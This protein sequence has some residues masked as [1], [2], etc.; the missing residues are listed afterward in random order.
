MISPAYVWR[1]HTINKLN[2][3]EIPFPT[4]TTESSGKVFVDMKSK[5]GICCK[6][7]DDPVNAKETN[8]K[9]HILILLLYSI[10]GY[11]NMVL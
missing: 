10:L 8:K 4:T 5:L 3:L 1:T 6:F 11:Y 2:N 7:D 9:P